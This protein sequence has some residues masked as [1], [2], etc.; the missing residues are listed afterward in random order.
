M[1]PTKWNLTEV[2]PIPK[3]A[4]YERGSNKRPFSLLSIVSKV[5]ERVVC[6]QFSSYVTS[7][8]R[9]SNN[10]SGNKKFHST[11]TSV[12][13]TTDMILQAMDNKKLT[14]MVLLDMSKA[15]DSVDHKLMISKLQDAGASS[16]CIEWFRSYLSG[17]QQV[18][19]ISSALSEPLP[20]VSGIP[21]GSVLAPLLFSKYTN[22]LTSVPIKRMA[23]SYV[24]ETKLL[25]SFNLKQKTPTIAHIEE[26]LFNVSK[27]C[28]QNYLLLNPD[29]TKLLVL[30][31]DRR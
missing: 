28:C 22:D 11:E 30:E 9:L 20:I 10:Q 6:N 13:E 8:G 17:R 1:F 4:D 12:I 2:T 31:A 19:R 7:D 3:D 25:I 5:C 18:V 29:K 27:W 14:A 15:F 26:D 24:D 21:Q 16:S 23:K